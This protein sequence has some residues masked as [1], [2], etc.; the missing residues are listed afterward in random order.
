MAQLLVYFFRW[1]LAREEK[2]DLETPV[3]SSSNSERK[4][5]PQEGEAQQVS[6]QRSPGE[7]IVAAPGREGSARDATGK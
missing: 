7:A 6:F 4:G 3:D 5:S 1:Y 2:E